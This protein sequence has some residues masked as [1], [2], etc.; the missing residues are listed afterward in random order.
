MVNGF[1]MIAQRLAPTVM[2]CSISSAVSRNVSVLPSMAL[3]V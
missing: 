1:K 2:P 3:E